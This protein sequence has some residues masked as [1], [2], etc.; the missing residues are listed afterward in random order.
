MSCAGARPLR[1][2]SR[3]AKNQKALLRNSLIRDAEK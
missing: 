2:L 1:V 3:K